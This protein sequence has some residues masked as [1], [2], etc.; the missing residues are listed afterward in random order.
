MSELRPD[1]AAMRA[2]VGHIFSGL[3]EELQDSFIELAWTDARDGKL[4]HSRHFWTGELDELVDLAVRQN[5]KPGQN[6]YIGAA[7]RGP[8]TPRE[9]RSSDKD[10]C[11][12]TALYADFDDEGTLERA[13]KV[14]AGKGVPPTAKVI[15]GRHPHLRGQLWWR[16]RE[17]LRDPDDCRRINRAIADA[18]GG[19]LVVHNPGRVL[20]LGGSVAWPKKKGRVAETT[21]FEELSSR[22]YAV[23][24]IE[25]AFPI[26]QTG[27]EKSVV[28]MGPPSRHLDNSQRPSPDIDQLLAQAGPGNWHMSILRAIARMVACGW[29]DQDILART[30]SHTLAGWTAEQTRREVQAMIDGARRKGYGNVRRA[31]RLIPDVPPG[32]ASQPLAR[33]DASTQLK[34]VIS[35]WFDRAVPLAQARKELARRHRAR[36]ARKLPRELAEEI[37]KEV[38][39]E[40]GVPNLRAAPRLAV[41]AAAGL[42]KTM[43]VVEEIMAR[44]EV[45]KLRVWIL[46][47][48]IDLADRLAE[49]FLH[50]SFDPAHAPGPEIRVMRGRLARTVEERRPREPKTMCRKPDAADAAGRLGLNVYK[51]LCKSGAG[52][53]E[54]YDRCPWVKQW[55]DHG[56]GVRIWS[57]EYLHLP[58]LSDYPPPDMVVCDESVVEVLAGGLQFAPDRLTEAPTWAEGDQ[59]EIVTRCLAD[60]HAAL[61]AGGPAL[62]ALMARGLDRETLAKA[63]DIA[64]GGEDGDTGITPDMPEAE[65]VERLDALEESERE[66]IARLLRQLAKEIKLPRGVSHAVELQRN[67][68]V[69]VDGRLERQNRVSVRWRRKVLVG[70][71]RPLLVI[72]AD[73]DEEITK[74]LFG[75]PLEHVAIPVRR[76]AVVTQCHS[77]NFS[78]QSLLGFEGAAPDFN[79]KA[80]RRLENVKLIIRR[81]AQAARLLVVCPLPVRRAITGEKEPRLPISCEWEGATISHFGRIRGVDDWKGYEAGMTIG[82]E[83]PPPLAV[84]ALARSVWDDDPVPLNLPGSYAKAMRGYRLRGG[85]R[86]GV[87]VDVHPD[88]RV[89]RVLELKRERETLQAIDR[90]RLVHAD[91]I[92]DIYILCKLPLDLD[93]DR[94]EG[95]TDLL[96]GGGT[97]LERAYLRSQRGLPLVAGRISTLWPDLYPSEMSAKLSTFRELKDSGLDGFKKEI[98]SISLLKPSKTGGEYPG[99]RARLVQFGST[100]AVMIRIRPRCIAKGGHHN[101]SKALVAGDT[102]YFRSKVRDAMGCEVDFEHPTTCILSASAAGPKEVPSPITGE[103]A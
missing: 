17:P 77:S 40:Y 29:P 100:E 13:E 20:R 5:A 88:P 18:L 73:A 99:N 22:S 53:C 82:R 74:R 44:Q 65:A 21:A 58:K 9:R 68:S 32:Y 92:K 42:G 28:Q 34:S 69:Q 102:P 79:A 33:D 41:Q 84:E 48:T 23:E 89:Q 1:V 72:D 80:A 12:L 67:V 71:T 101:W 39:A 59:A 27:G 62:E 70:R 43:R 31:A 57:H 35:G 78:R 55:E 8:D 60:V 36:F 2:H 85:E 90:T 75:E 61:S 15:T 96:N 7:L 46:V 49:K 47:P 87:E 30:E 19:D 24:E 50:L 16:L 11:A 14:C 98:D 86:N 52:R 64:E 37:R 81:L 63:A 54:F 95:F 26:K 66:K 93:V 6:L 103:T 94:L 25:S 83:Q 56:P 4:R 51:T 45:W 97:R 10:F 91:K 38:K 3:P 76:N